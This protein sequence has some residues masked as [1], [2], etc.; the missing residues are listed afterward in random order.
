MPGIEKPLKLVDQ[1]SPVLQKYIDQMNAAVQRNSEAEASVKQLEKQM[2]LLA[3]TQD[4]SNRTYANAVEAYNS[5]IEANYRW[6]DG[7]SEADRGNLRATA[8]FKQLT[9]AGFLMS[10]AIDDANHAVNQMNWEAIQ[11]SLAQQQA[12]DSAKEVEQEEDNSAAKTTELEQKVKRLTDAMIRLSNENERLKNQQERTAESGEKM[13]NV[14]GGKLLKK[15]TAMALFFVS[16]RRLIKYFRE[17]AERAPDE[18]AAKYTAFGDTVKDAFAGVVVSFMNGF[19]GPLEKIT[20]IMQGGSVQKLLRALETIASVLGQ[21]VGGVLALFAST[22]EWIGEHIGQIAV[23]GAVAFGLLAAKMA[24]AAVSALLVHWPLLLIIAAV[25]TLMSILEGL[26]VT[27]D[28]IFRFIGGLVGALYAFVYNIIADVYNAFAAIAE[29]IA[30]CFVDP[31]GI[32][33][34]LFYHMADGVLK[35]LEKIANGIDSIF[36]GNLTA[37]VQDWRQGLE[38]FFAG[39]DVEYKVNLARMGK[40]DYASTIASFADKGESLGG[41]LSSFNLANMQAQSV[42]SLDSIDQSTSAIAKSVT[43]EDLKDLIDMAERAFVAQVNLTSQTPV[44]TINGANTGNTEADR[45]NLAKAIETILTEQ[46]AA[47][48][49]SSPYVY[50]GA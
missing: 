3:K 6:A 46:L 12:A 9:D 32:V 45:R 49:T 2:N 38:D 22:L 44:I 21:M 36:G 19:S 37:K 4:I 11:M 43:E 27:T 48:S 34:K 25:V 16:T 30:N 33:G 40:L 35:T 41:S 17:A 26:G 5:A 23:I 50:S 39:T 20:A 7:L 8:S 18:L 14:L 24:I 10:K 15:L 42:K 1:F 47:G 29:F 31:V 13:G 28:K